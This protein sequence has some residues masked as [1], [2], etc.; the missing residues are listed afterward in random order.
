MTVLTRRPVLRWLVPVAVAVLLGVGGT[1]LGVITAAARGGL[2]HRSA[3]TLLVD[4][5]KARLAGLSGTIVQNAD[6]GLPSLP[7]AGGAGS[8]DLTSLVAGSHTLRVWYA[9]PDRVRLALLGSL[10]ESDVI[11][12]GRDLWTWSSATRS[13]RHLTVPVSKHRMPGSLAGASPVTPQEA[14]D[15][16]LAALDPSTRVST[17]GTAVVAGRPAYELVLRPRDAGSLVESVRIAIDGATHVPTRVQ[18]FG[19]KHGDPAFEVGFTS[20]DPAPPDS[21]VFRFNPPPGTKVTQ[22]HLTRPAPQRLGAGP[23]TGSAP[24]VVGKG[25]TSVVVATVPPGSATGAGPLP[26]VLTRLPLVHGS[27]GSGRLLQGTV[28]SALLTD[29]GRVAVGA[30]RPD[31]LY[32]ALARR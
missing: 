23:R 10:G 24:E 11:R 28:F 21:S 7:G 25:W 29:D 17:D 6:L 22:S 1:T 5:Q 9:G 4:V 18:V 30:V 12:T 32:A 31:R 2:P 14:A 3:S 8:S 20:F 16:A 19:T 13:A 26:R 15:A 27:W